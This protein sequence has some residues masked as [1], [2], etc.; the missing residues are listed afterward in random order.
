MKKLL[1]VLLAMGVF[2]VGALMINARLENKRLTAMIA[3]PGWDVL[4]DIAEVKK[5]RPKTAT[6]RINNQQTR[7]EVADQEGRPSFTPV[8]QNRQQFEE[9]MK[10]S[11]AKYLE[12]GKGSQTI[13]ITLNAKGGK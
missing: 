10:R 9:L 2:L 3:Q 1:F 7:Q 11:R 4:P 8:I 13:N 12:P 5:I 6:P